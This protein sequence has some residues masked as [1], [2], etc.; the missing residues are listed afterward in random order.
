M[1]RVVAAC[2]YAVSRSRSDEAERLLSRRQE[3]EDGKDL[4]ER[5]GHAVVS[6]AY[7]AQCKY[8]T[9]VPRKL[10]RCRFVFS[11]DWRLW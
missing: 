7:M 10:L 1:A 6:T 3:F 4:G 8:E 2:S 11:K 9:I 5:R